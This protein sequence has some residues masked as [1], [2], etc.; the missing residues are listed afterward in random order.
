MRIFL[1]GYMGCGKTNFG[2]YLAKKVNFNYIDLDGLFEEKY[3]ISIEKFFA[4]KGQDEFRKTE[5]QLLTDTLNYDNV[6]I[7]TGG[8]TPCFYDNMKIIKDNGISFYIKMS[9][10]DLFNGLTNFKNKR[11]L[12]KKMTKKDL[13]NFIKKQLKER[14]QYYFQA[15]YTIDITT[16][17]PCSTTYEQIMKKLME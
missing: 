9:T 5:H 10:D 14:E 13:E 7:A 4:D 16:G 15:D 2:K 8:G 11:P 17:Q 12:L 3:N 1:I 6:V